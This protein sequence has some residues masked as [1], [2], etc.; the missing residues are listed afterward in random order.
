MAK[1]NETGIKGEQIAE[2]F[3]LKKGYKIL[4]R[5]WRFGRREVDIIALQGNMLV[6]IEVKTRSS[7]LF[8]Y[9]E[10]SIG[11]KKQG[12]LKQAAEAFMETEIAYTS[13]RFDTISILMKDG[14][15]REVVHFEDA[16]Y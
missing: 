11:S 16:F 2:N 1:H 7:Y 3:L 12:F 5:N 13:A 6:F 9:P 15:L 10:E 8:G 14:E 4:H